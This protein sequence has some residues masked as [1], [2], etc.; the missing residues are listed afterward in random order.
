MA[1]VT[2]IMRA[3]IILCALS[4]P[5]HAQVERVD[6]ELVLLV[7]ASYSI[8]RAELQF[9]RLGYA[10][11]L[12]HPDVLKAIRLGITGRIAVSFMEWA[13]A[14]SQDVIVPWMIIDGEKSARSFAMKLLG[15]RR[16]A[17][18]SN[19]IGSAISAAQEHIEGNAFEGLRKIIDFSGDSA[20]NWGRHTDR[21]GAC[22][23]AFG[24]DHH[25]RSC[26]A[27]P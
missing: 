15:A 18:G 6:L 23:R 14:D 10:A 8:D 17:T 19:A 20:N 9:Q 27:L 21:G 25:Q 1:R 12:Q 7:D 16:M 2:H 5:S 13:D 11:A 3:V 24:G 26:R 4:A 22:T